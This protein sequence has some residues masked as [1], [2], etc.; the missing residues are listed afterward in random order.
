MQGT[1]APAA[2]GAEIEK[3]GRSSFSFP[4]SQRARP[5]TP[6]PTTTKKKTV[7]GMERKSR[8]HAYIQML[9]LVC[10]INCV[11][12]DIAA[13]SAERDGKRVRAC[14]RA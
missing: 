13:S 12:G 7:V 4:S 5:P 2:A 10:A 11:H 6:A 3:D 9:V 14:M 8:L 1:Q